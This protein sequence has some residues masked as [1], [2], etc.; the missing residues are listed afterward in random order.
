MLGRA[1]RVHIDKESTTIIDG[2][3]AKIR[4]RSHPPCQAAAWATWI[5][6]ELGSLEETTARPWVS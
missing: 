1:K 6:E 2:A 5:T 3:G 4:R